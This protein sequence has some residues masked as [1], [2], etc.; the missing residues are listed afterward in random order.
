M[1]EI[2]YSHQYNY[3]CARRELRGVISFSD[4]TL[5]GM[6]L[7]V[8]LVF[9]RRRRRSF[10]SQ[11]EIASVDFKVEDMKRQ[12]WLKTPRISAADV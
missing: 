2:C 4:R 10:V 9:D 11:L 1:N 7:E 6:G 12:Q 8:G 5:A 3:R